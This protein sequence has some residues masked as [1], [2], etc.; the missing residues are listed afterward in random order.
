MEGQQLFTDNKDKFKGTY[1]HKLD[2][3]NFTEKYFNKNNKPVNI[4]FDMS[5][6][7]FTIGIFS[8]PFPAGI[9]AHIYNKE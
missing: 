8:G 6:A 9:N 1:Q 2:L 4:F 7:N 3:S 5:N